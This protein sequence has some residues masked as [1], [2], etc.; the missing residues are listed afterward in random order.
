MSPLCWSFPQLWHGLCFFTRNGRR[1]NR[2][3]LPQH[4]NN[5]NVRSQ[6]GQC[7]FDCTSGMCSWFFPW[8]ELFLVM[9]VGCSVSV[10]LH[11][12]PESIW[13]CC[14][15]V[16]WSHQEENG[17]QECLS[18]CYVHA[19][20]CVGL[21]G[22]GETVPWFQHK[23]SFCPPIFSFSSGQGR[24]IITNIYLPRASQMERWFAKHI[25][26]AWRIFPLFSHY[27]HA[28]KEISSFFLGT[29]PLNFWVRSVSKCEW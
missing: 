14:P 19:K 7:F 9:E 20:M 24:E 28:K 18:V 1:I 8:D 23:G 16:G 11:P 13:L 5:T 2:R 3:F 4:H 25:L 17:E 15:W 6:W 10:P 27:L 29:G 12:P 26:K 22:R 21:Q